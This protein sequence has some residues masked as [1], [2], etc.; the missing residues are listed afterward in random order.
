MTSWT[1]GSL[2]KQIGKGRAKD[3]PEIETKKGRKK[4]VTAGGIEPST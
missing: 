3:R 4:R 1:G 2:E